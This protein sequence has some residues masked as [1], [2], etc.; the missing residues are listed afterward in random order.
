[1][2]HSTKLRWGPAEEALLLH[3]RETMTLDALAEKYDVTPAR[4]SQVLKRAK[5]RLVPAKETEPA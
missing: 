5:G 4:I 2:K 1:M 3:L